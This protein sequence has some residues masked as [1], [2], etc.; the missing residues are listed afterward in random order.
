MIINL[1]N[2]NIIA[3]NPLFALD[4]FT[5]TRGMIFKKFDG[6]DAMVFSHCN[7]IHTMFM[8]MHLDV[9]FVDYDNKI[10]ALRQLRPWVP[11]V[12]VPKARTVIELP[13]GTIQTTKPAIGNVL[14]IDAE[15]IDDEF[16]EMSDFISTSDL[17]IPI[18]VEKKK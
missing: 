4:F 8:Q 6:F 10:C 3:V 16:S 12:R 1:T 14:N 15:V 17:I 11:F 9:I 7:C 18:N 13:S 5:R 2:K